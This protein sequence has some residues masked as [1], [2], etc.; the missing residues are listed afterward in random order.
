MHRR[1]IPFL[2]SVL[3]LIACQP[4]DATLATPTA[5]TSNPRDNLITQLETFTPIPTLPLV[6]ELA[7]AT[8]TPTST[9]TSTPTAPPTLTHTTTPRPTQT[10][11]IDE[12][13]ASSP[14]PTITPTE[15]LSRTDHYWLARPI[16]LDDDRVHWVDR[17]YPY[18]STQLGTRDVH[19][20][21]EF[22]NNRFTPILAS[23]GGQVLFAGDD[24]ETRIGPEYDYY[25]NVVIIAHDFASPEGLP[26]YTLYGH[27][28]DIAVSA[29]DV[30]ERGARVGRVGSTGIAIGAHLHFEVRV[31]DPFDYRN[32]RNPDLW[33]EPYRNHGTLAG[34]VVGAADI[35][36]VVLE[37]RGDGFW[38]ETYTYAGSQVNS[39]PLWNENFTLGDLR[40]GE[41]EVFIGDGL[42]NFL[43]RERVTIVA[44]ET[45]WLDVRLSA[46]E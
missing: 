29:G 39:D 45:T 10:P 35:F 4:D 28:Q 7:T 25:G 3:I 21:V 42:G 40:A 41:Y 34:R 12:D 38:R 22:V 27:M 13:R 23:A 30:I 5:L 46:D 36:N 6:R 19:L 43:F 16:A 24:S 15:E 14:T 44:G 11:A 20:G 2:V 17:T 31:D 1:L 32:T 37:V 33:I 26:V 8:D 9:V 18:G